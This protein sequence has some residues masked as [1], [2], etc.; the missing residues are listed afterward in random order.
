M[1]YTY[2]SP[3]VTCPTALYPSTPSR[4]IAETTASEIDRSGRICVPRRLR[5]RAAVDSEIAVIGLYDRLESWTL[6]EWD[7]W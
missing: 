5:A 2:T 7:S 3:S 1:R 6:K 4:F